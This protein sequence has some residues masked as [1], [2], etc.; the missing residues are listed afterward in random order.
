MKRIP[1]RKSK[2]KTPTSRAGAAR[3]HGDASRLDA[4]YQQV[5]AVL[6][7]ARDRAWQAVN[8]TMVQAY[9]EV[10]R[11]IVEEEQAGKEKAG[12]GERVIDGLSERLRAELGKAYDRSNLFHMRTFFLAYPIVDAL[13]RQ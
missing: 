12:Y 2:A 5:R 10:G 3:Q 11:I 1:S 6:A 4:V 7:S 9:R 13:R 8:T